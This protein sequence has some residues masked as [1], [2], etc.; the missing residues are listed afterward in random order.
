MVLDSTVVFNEAMYN[1]A[2]ATED[3]LERVERYNQMSINMDISG[4][5]ME[6][7]IAYIFP[8]GSTAPSHG[9]LVVAADPV[10]PGAATGLATAIGPFAGR[11]SNGGQEIRL[12]NRND[13]RLSVIDYN[14]NAPWPAG[15]DR[16]RFTLARIDQYSAVE[17]AEKC[18]PESTS[19]LTTIQRTHTV[20]RTQRWTSNPAAFRL[21]P[22]GQA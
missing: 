16:T 9:D 18:P 10:A 22:Q 21:V 4:W 19:R 2:G 5:R 20:Q 17:L 11:L 6:G 8:E 12:V 14:D 1:P 15:A 7:G 13:R 3:A